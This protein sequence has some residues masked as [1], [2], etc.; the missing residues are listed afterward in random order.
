MITADQ[1]LCHAI[2]DYVIQSDWMANE[3]TKR[4]LAALAHVLTYAVPFLFLRHD[5]V[6][7]VQ[8]ARAARQPPGRRVGRAR[9]FYFSDQGRRCRGAGPR[10]VAGP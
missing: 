7:R 5:E 4:S 1:L 10:D 2:G 6:H 9:P 3:K 8:A